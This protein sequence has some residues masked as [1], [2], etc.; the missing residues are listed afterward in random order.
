MIMLEYQNIKIN[1]PN[2]MFH[3]PK[4]KYLG[5]NVKVK[6]DLSNCVTKAGGD[7]SDFAKNN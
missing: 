3:F 4:P 7:T 2:A 1:L 5:A 6:L